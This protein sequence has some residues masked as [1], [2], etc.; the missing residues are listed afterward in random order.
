MK[1]FFLAALLAASAAFGTPAFADPLSDIK[2]FT[3]SDV[4]AAEATY[5]A[6]PSVP[7]YAAATQ[8]LGF[9]DTTL[10]QPGAPIS[11][12]NLAAPQGAVSAV[13]DLDVALNTATNGLSPAVLSLNQNC[14]GYVED[15]KAEAAYK[16]AGLGVNLFGVVKF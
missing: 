4:K 12:G 11:F 2:S 13:A 8:C 6:N 7:T 10:S 14:G 16:T 9:L 3:L 5:A 1:K 15:L